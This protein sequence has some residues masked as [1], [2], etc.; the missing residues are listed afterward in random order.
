MRK[1]I[2]IC[3]MMILIS[4]CG[5]SYPNICPGL[6]LVKKRDGDVFT[7]ETRK[8]IFLNKKTIMRECY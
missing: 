1:I 7:N 6:K 8:E 4:S 2:S 3:L 5:N